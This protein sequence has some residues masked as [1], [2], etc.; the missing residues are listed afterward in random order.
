VEKSTAIHML[1]IVADGLKG[2]NREVVFVGGATVALY[3]DDPAVSTPRPTDDVDCTVE[4]T[5]RQEYYQL[6]K[7]V[8]KLG[9]KNKTEKGPICRWIYSGITVDIIPSEGVVLGFRNSWY[10][11]G[12]THAQRIVLPNKTEISV[13][14]LPYFLASKFEAFRDRGKNE[15]RTSSDFEDIVFVLDGCRTAEQKLAA[16]PTD[17]RK[18]LAA[19]YKQLSPSADFME[20]IT[21]NLANVRDHAA[22]SRRIIDILK[23]L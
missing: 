12:I 17:V 21:A 5:S 14:T 8:R 23:G 22:R 11:A 16:A 2:L 4:I 15:P 9:F 10:P 19:E 6:E 1:E 13:F 3:V 20:G 7:E 18:F